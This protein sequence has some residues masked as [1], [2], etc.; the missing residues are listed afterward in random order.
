[1]GGFVTLTDT[2]RYIAKNIINCS[3]TT[4]GIMKANGKFLASIVVALFVLTFLATA[5]FAVVPQTI[6][7]QG[8]LADSEGAPVNGT[9][10]MTFAIYNAPTGGE[11]LWSETQPSV[12]V[13][14]G[15]F[16]V[17]LGIANAIDL[18]FDEQYYLGV[19]VNG[20]GEMTPRAVLVSV[21]YALRAK[22]ADSVGASSVTSAEI[23]DGTI[24]GADIT[25]G[26]VTGA[27]L[28]VPLE[29]V[30]LREFGGIINGTNTTLTGWGSGVSGK[31]SATGNIGELGGNEAGVLG[32]G[33]GGT[34]GKFYG[35]VEVTGTI[36]GDGSG[37]TGTTLEGKT[38]SELVALLDSRYGN[39]GDSLVADF[40]A[41]PLGVVVDNT[42]D[43]TDLSQGVPQ[44]W[45]WDFGDTG[46][47]TLQNPSHTYTS[48]GTYT[49]SLTVGDGV[50]SNTTTKADYINVY[51]FPTGTLIPV[52]SSGCTYTSIAVGADNLPVIS[53]YAATNLKVAQCVNASCSNG[54]NI[55]QLDPAGGT[56]TSIAIGADG[57]PVISY[58][59]GTSNDLM[60]AHCG[61]A[62]CQSG[63]TINT[64]DSAGI[65][66]DFTS[67]AIGADNLPVISYRDLTNG[68]LKVAHCGDAS[69]TPVTNTITTVDSAG[70]AGQYSSIAI[71]AD[72]LPVSSYYNG[73]ALMVL[74]C[75]DASCSTGNTINTV[76]A[77]GGI[78]TSIAIGADGLP[79]ISYFDITIYDL[80]V[81][82]CGDAACTPATNTITTVDSGNVGYYT[83]IAIG[84]DGLPVISYYDATNDDL[85]VLHCGD[86]SCTP[87]TNTITT[88]DSAGDVGK[89][90]SIAVGADGLPVISYYDATNNYLKVAKCGD[91]TCLAWPW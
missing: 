25:D 73:S 77:L 27:K 72:G 84:S 3:N 57:L 80:K 66:G 32:F 52:D 35:D 64:V 34:A 81:A 33:P 36:S 63:N 9:V 82:H 29:V 65:V 38:L 88:V 89:W 55:T 91:A 47:S 45:L 12:T 1:M 58:Y 75:G 85:K 51:P 8:R 15:A 69:C 6:N 67:I 4:G 2:Y 59:N 79:V 37:L 43:F 68:D 19:N 21:P 70:I 76:D 48:T 5:A 39:L 46:T 56:H 42:V 7:Y 24:T 10:S 26:T 60:V 18:P 90:T 83:S 14:D 28:S 44:S 49:V 20:D 17:T 53:Y 50:T 31:H 13:T 16:G 11:L 54:Q 74:H 40:S 87:A 23:A 86:A 30:G 41:V 78:F 62:S 71:G 61:D 22:E